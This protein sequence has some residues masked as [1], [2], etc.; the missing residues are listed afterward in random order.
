MIFEPIQ[1][2]TFSRNHEG[3]GHGDACQELAIA[4]QSE[5][6]EE[7]LGSLGQ[8][9]LLLPWCHFPGL[10]QG[11]LGPN[12]PCHCSQA[13]CVLDLRCPPNNQFSPLSCCSLT[14]PN[15][16][17]VSD[18]PS[19]Q[20]RFFFFCLVLFCFLFFLSHQPV[21]P[22]K[23][24]IIYEEGVCRCVCLKTGYPRATGLSGVETVA[25][26]TPFCSLV[27]LVGHARGPPSALAKFYSQHRGD[28]GRRAGARRLE[29]LVIRER[30]ISPSHQALPSFSRTS[31]EG[32][33]RI[34]KPEP[35]LSGCQRLPL[36]D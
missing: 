15:V 8:L 16:L 24:G 12:P 9:V 10:L 36:G 11:P 18:T 19:T 13:S 27:A 4:G 2:S 22:S 20:L 14:S 21:D 1:N 29:N 26:L 17:H 3:S 31:K 6:R 28:P 25:L 23:P 33:P 35:Q 5:W 32:G 30:S 7:G 34:Y